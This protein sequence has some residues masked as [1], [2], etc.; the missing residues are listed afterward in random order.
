[1]SNY[2]GHLTASGQLPNGFLFLAV[3]GLHANWII[4]KT[5]LVE[6]RGTHE[7][8][9]EVN[10]RECVYRANRE[11]RA[12]E[13]SIG[14]LLVVRIRPIRFI[15]GSPPRSVRRTPCSTRSSYEALVRTLVSLRFSRDTPRGTGR[16]CDVSFHWEIQRH[17][18]F[19]FLE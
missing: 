6:F 1:M 10:C 18:R 19:F 14:W 11:R 4:D 5:A 2:F 15:E 9:A 13:T 16:T 3:R 17:F 7:E 8:P 12:L